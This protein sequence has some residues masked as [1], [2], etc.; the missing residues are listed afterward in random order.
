MFQEHNYFETPKIYGKIG[1]M[2]FQNCS[3]LSVIELP[4]SIKELGEFAFSSC[5]K[6]TSVIILSNITELKEATFE[7]L[8]KSLRNRHSYLFDENGYLQRRRDINIKAPYLS[9]QYSQQYLQRL[10]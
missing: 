7:K 10:F 1:K 2:A 6:L 5:S 8:T 9:V 4:K 3:N